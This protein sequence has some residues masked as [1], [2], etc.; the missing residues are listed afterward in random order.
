MSKG[1]F[2]EPLTLNDFDP[3]DWVESGETKV[4]TGYR[5]SEELLLRAIAC[6]NALDGISDVEAW[7][8]TIGEL[9]GKAK[10]VKKLP[11]THII[12]FDR[13]IDE[14]KAALAKLEELTE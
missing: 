7:M 3:I 12:A 9:A 10:L 14:L 5:I 6:T 4:V 13:P 1:K 2:G 8:Q 11:K